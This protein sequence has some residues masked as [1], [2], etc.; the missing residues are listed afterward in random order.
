MGKIFVTGDLHCEIHSTCLASRNF[1]EGKSLTK[2]DVLIVC[3]DFGYV[4]TA[5]PKSKY[6]EIQEHWTEWLDSK[7]WTTLFVDGNHE[8]HDLLYQLPTENMFGSIVGRWSP[9]IYHLKRGHVYTINGKTFFC[10]GGALSTDRGHSAID[11]T[12]PSFWEIR[13]LNKKNKK[14]KPTE[15][16]WWEQEVPSQE[17]FNFGLNSLDKCNWKVDYVITH[18][19]PSR[20]ILDLPKTFF[21]ERVNDPTTKYFDVISERLV[22]KKWFF[23]HFHCNWKNE[24]GIYNCLFERVDQLI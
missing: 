5:N 18:T 16:D 11:S 15:I 14:D 2:E 23:G 21:G 10:M 17:E 4:W 24:F 22:F 13:A 19:C 1:P 9:S 6:F 3:G 12:N 7:P 20:I 8:N